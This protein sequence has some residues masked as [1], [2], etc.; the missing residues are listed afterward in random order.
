MRWIK[1]EDKLPPVDI[2]VLFYAGRII[3][4]EYTYYGGRDRDDYRW[5][6]DHMGYQAVPDVT[7]W[8]PLPCR[9]ED[10]K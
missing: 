9:P 8:M 4:G 7:H 2:P 3:F 5:C 6:E 1:V 10:E